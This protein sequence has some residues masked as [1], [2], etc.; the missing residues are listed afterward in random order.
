MSKGYTI[1][2]FIEA[3]SNSSTSQ[4]T[5]D[6]IFNTVSPRLGRFSQKAVALDN[7]LGGQ[8]G[9]IALGAG[10]FSSYG[11]TPRGRVLKALRNRKN[12]GIV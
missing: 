12:N 8:T 11:S 2:F 7:W 4:V 10:K 9:A 5:R 3:L 1:S 6:G